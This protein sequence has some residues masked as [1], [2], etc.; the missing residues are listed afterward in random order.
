MFKKICLFMV[1][2][3]SFV[4]IASAAEKKDRELFFLFENLLFSYDNV[5]LNNSGIT[6]YSLLKKIA[7]CKKSCFLCKY[8]YDESW[9]YH[10]IDCEKDVYSKIGEGYFVEL[11]EKLAQDAS[12][13]EIDEEFTEILPSF[14]LYFMH[15]SSFFPA[16]G[17]G[18]S[19]L[20]EN[21]LPLS[22]FR[23]RPNTSPV[24]ELYKQIL[25]Q[26]PNVDCSKLDL[27]HPL[28]RRVIQILKEESTLCVDLSQIVKTVNFGTSDSIFFVDK[29]AC[30]NKDWDDI[31]L[32]L[33]SSGAPINTFEAL[34]S[35][36]S[37]FF[38]QHSCKSCL[39]IK[40][41]HRVESSIKYL[42]T[43]YKFLNNSFRKIL[44]SGS[45]DKKS[46]YDKSLK[47]RA[48]CCA[49]VMELVSCHDF[50][51]IKPFQVEGSQNLM[52]EV[53]PP[54][55][56]DFKYTTASQ[57]H[58]AWTC[59][60]ECFFCALLNN[61]S[62]LMGSHIHTTLRDSYGFLRPTLTPCGRSFRLS[63]GLQP[64]SYARIVGVALIK[65]D[66]VLEKLARNQR[67]ELKSPTYFKRLMLSKTT[68]NET[69]FDANNM[70]S[71]V[72]L[73]EHLLNKCNEINAFMLLQQQIKS[74]NVIPYST[75]YKCNLYSAYK[76]NET[77][78]ETPLVDIMLH[79]QGYID[80]SIRER[81]DIIDNAKLPVTL[82][83]ILAQ[84]YIDYMRLNFL[85]Q[86]KDD[87]GTSYFYRKSVEVIEKTLED[88]SI[89]NTIYYYSNK[90]TKVQ[91]VTYEVVNDKIMKACFF[92]DW[93]QQATFS[94]I[95]WGKRF[96]A[97]KNYKLY[98]DE[99]SYYQ[100]VIFNHL[101]NFPNTS[102]ICDNSIATIYYLDPYPTLISVNSNINFK[103]R[104]TLEKLSEIFNDSQNSLAIVILDISSTPL[105]VQKE[106]LE[107]WES[108]KNKN[109]K[110]LIFINSGNKNSQMGLDKYQFGQINIY[111]KK[112]QLNINSFKLL[113]DISEASHKFPLLI[114]LKN[115]IETMFGRTM[116]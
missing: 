56:S 70:Y 97:S 99:S 49:K 24:T 50:K 79:I 33:V 110:S 17:D 58:L 45:K 39:A 107:A 101:I 55:R 68:Q 98:M 18:Y 66:L 54:P 43:A 31:F 116:Y 102:K 109:V 85:L 14:L 103:R 8:A 114:F 115:E 113:E 106:L 77:P 100:S 30:S 81:I 15:N 88:L 62:K 69:I 105:W 73:C 60:I 25:A 12:R 34:R 92:M 9:Y 4:F 52:I 80:Q 35:A 63:M 112:D 95:I 108:G 86:K 96:F 6:T 78:E 91:N 16:L 93:G 29:N 10:P 87:M 111:F 21:I 40:S 23:D 19:R 75:Y 1:G 67:Y 104:N 83:Y 3:I 59:F 61:Q 57:E 90:V 20:T 71:I 5:S 27:I 2:I 53:F 28:N 38:K 46:I 64:T 32:L 26:C 11:I 72:F 94:S 82:N 41:R 7:Y 74:E 51:Y 13:L 37:V 76:N 89:F 22:Y 65:L 44:D 84:I 47:Y 36:I 48:N 42:C